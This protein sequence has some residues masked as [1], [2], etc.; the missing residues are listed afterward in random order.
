MIRRNPELIIKTIGHLA[1][2]ILLSFYDTYGQLPYKD[3]M[4]DSVFVAAHK[5]KSATSYSGGSVIDKFAFNKL[6]KVTTSINVED[7]DETGVEQDKMNYTK[8]SFDKKHNLISSKTYR[9]GALERSEYNVYDAKDQ[10]IHKISIDNMG[11]VKV[12]F[13]AIYDDKGNK[14]EEFINSVGAAT[15]NRWIYRYNAD[16][17]LVLEK[18]Y[19][20]FTELYRTD[21]TLYDKNGNKTAQYTIEY[22][23]GRQVTLATNFMIWYPG[24]KPVITQKYRAIYDSHNNKLADTNWQGAEMKIYNLQNNIFNDNGEQ[25]AYLRYTADGGDE[26]N[27]KIVYTYKK[28]LV[29]GEKRFANNSEFPNFK[30][31]NRSISELKWEYTFY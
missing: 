2:F 3:K 31:W 28:G 17:K 4:Y 18:Q 27:L 1:F 22:P 20:D 23:A 26:R 29:T 16:K 13:S 5:L 10:L 30:D 24:T 7:E 8:D 9:Q 12:E 11:N 14:I 15:T 6:G 21:S 25:V 19:K